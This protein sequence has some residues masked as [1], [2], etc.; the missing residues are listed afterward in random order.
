[1]SFTSFTMR[2]NSRGAVATPKRSAQNWKNP[3][4]GL[5]TQIFE[6]V[7]ELRHKNTGKRL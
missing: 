2:V 4:F 6:I 7:D 5:K 3:F 1:M